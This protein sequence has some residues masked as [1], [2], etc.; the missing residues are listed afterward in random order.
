MIQ[1]FDRKSYFCHRIYILEYAF[2]SNEEV[3]SKVITTRNGIEKDSRIIANG[4]GIVLT[5][6]GVRTAEIK[7]NI[8]T[9]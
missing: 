8:Y 4:E 9:G 3:S 7:R 6:G 2:P 5:D 1:I